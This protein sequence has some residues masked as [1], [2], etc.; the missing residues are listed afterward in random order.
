MAVYKVVEVGDE[1][2][3]GKAQKVTK[4]GRT[5]EKLLDN[6]R[7]TMYAYDGVGLAAPQI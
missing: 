3:R 2:L 5:I 4:F 7:E 1:I 6:M